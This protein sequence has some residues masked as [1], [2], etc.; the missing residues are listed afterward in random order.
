MRKHAVNYSVTGKDRRG[1][2]KRGRAGQG[3]ARVGCSKT[4]MQELKFPPERK[5]TVYTFSIL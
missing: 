4:E 3:S 2:G 5:L 1:E